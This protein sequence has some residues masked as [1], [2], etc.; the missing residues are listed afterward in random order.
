MKELIEKILNFER[1]F[2][3][4]EIGVDKKLLMEL[5]KMGV[6]QISLKTNKHTFFKIT[7]PEKLKILLSKFDVK[8]DKSRPLFDSIVGY[9]E[10]KELLRRVVES[11]VATHILLLGPR[12]TA[13]TLFLL[14]LTKIPN[15]IY[16]NCYITYAGLFDYLLSKPNLLLID[17]LDNV[18]D[19]NVFNLLINVCE[20]G[21][22][23]KITTNEKISF[24]TNTK[25]IATANTTKRIPKPLLS[26]F[27]ILQFREYNDEEFINIAKNL[28]KNYELDEETKDYIIQKTIAT[29]DVRNVIKLAN[30]CKNKEDVEKFAK[31]LKFL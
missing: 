19:K 22:V 7:D 1:E 30:I 4:W 12:A 16:T 26:R 21:I 10:H 8:I 28:L 5:V 9:D 6:L 2:E 23:A 25:V 24:K 14:E 29:K 13:K 15:S 20:Y 18:V 31:I 3:A 11:D 27:L 17:Q